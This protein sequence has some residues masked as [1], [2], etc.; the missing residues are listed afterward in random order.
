[1]AVDSLKQKRQY[2]YLFIYIYTYSI[3]L[4]SPLVRHKVH[5]S[6]GHSVQPCCGPWRPSCSSWGNGGRR[7]GSCSTS[8]TS[9]SEWFSVLRSSIMSNHLPI[10]GVTELRKVNYCVAPFW[11]M[12]P[13]KSHSSLDNPLVISQKDTDTSPVR[14]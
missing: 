5:T 1:M 14:D 11:M 9:Y 6:Y 13:L 10:C 8:Y 12:C 2:I 3:D 7:G 4:F